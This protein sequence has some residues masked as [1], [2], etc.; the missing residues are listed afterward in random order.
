MDRINYEEFREAL[1]KQAIKNERVGYTSRPLLSV[2][3]V[4]KVFRLTESHNATPQ[5][6]ETATSAEKSHETD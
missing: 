6:H 4:L 2:N 3:D 1:V 5:Q